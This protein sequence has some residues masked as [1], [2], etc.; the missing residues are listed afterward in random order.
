[1]GYLGLRVGW[2]LISYKDLNAYLNLTTAL[3]YLLSL[4]VRGLDPHFLRMILL[5]LLLLFPT[6][7][8]ILAC[9]LAGS[10]FVII[11]E[12]L[13]LAGCVFKK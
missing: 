7:W 5:I 4:V 2:L 3:A 13:V 12:C 6:T 11:Y 10:C 9:G 8:V 1:M